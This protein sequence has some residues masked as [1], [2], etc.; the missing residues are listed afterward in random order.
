MRRKRRRRKT[1]SSPSLGRPVKVW[2]FLRTPGPGSREAAAPSPTLRNFP[3]A[4]TR[5]SCGTGPVGLPPPAAGP[6]PRRLLLKWQVPPSA[7]PASARARLQAAGGAGPGGA[8][9][10]AGPGRAGH[11]PGR[12]R[13]A[14]AVPSGESLPRALAAALSPR[15]PQPAPPRPPLSA[16]GAPGSAAE[17]QPPQSLSGSRFQRRPGPGRRQH[18]PRQIP[19][20]P[21]PES[22][23]RGREARPGAEGGGGSEAGRRVAAAAGGFFQRRIL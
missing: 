22:R 13:G 1:T 14:R 8:G 10:A 12:W 21:D 23:R 7:R 6:G 15:P 2:R 11:S 16:P 18:P 9:A 3:S 5:L 4:R 19:Q 20:S 17:P